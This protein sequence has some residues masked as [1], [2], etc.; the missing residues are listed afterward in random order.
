MNYLRL[1]LILFIFSFLI[2]GCQKDPDYH[3][4]TEHNQGITNTSVK[5][6]PVDQ[7]ISAKAKNLLGEDE[8][9]TSVQAI[10][11]DKHLVIAVSVPHLQRF[12][13]EKTKKRLDK[14]MK[15][16]FQ[17]HHVTLSTDKKIQLELE[18]LQ[19]E[20][21]NQQLS[22]KTLSKKLKHI[23]KLSKEET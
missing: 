4:T 18:Q 17:N 19:K 11:D 6:A 3:K 12:K 15:K 1:T 20:M 8:R 7:G 10:N 21:D 22:Q 9:I 2:V 14:Q 23:I 5:K 16:E 13:L